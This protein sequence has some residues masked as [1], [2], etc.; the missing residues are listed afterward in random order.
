MHCSNSAI[1]DLLKTNDP[2]YSTRRR[3]IESALDEQNARLAEID[4]TMAQLQKTLVALFTE[5]RQVQRRIVDYKMILHPI[6]RIPGD[7]LD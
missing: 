3:E 6:R 5:R 4:A 2:P 1:P 7:V